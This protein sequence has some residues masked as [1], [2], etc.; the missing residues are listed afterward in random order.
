MTIKS[1]VL[2]LV[3]IMIAIFGIIG[4]ADA[5]YIGQTG[6]EV[7]DLQ[8]TL[9]EAGYD[10][11]ALSSGVAQPGYFGVQTQRALAKYEA[12]KPRTF[13]ALSSPTVYEPVE[14]NGGSKFGSVNSTSTP[15]S[16]TLRLSDVMN[17]D[18]VIVRPTGAAASKTLT[19]FASSTAANWLPKAGDTQRTC[20][21]NAT[22]S[23][24]ATIVFAAGAGIDL[25]AT[26]TNLTVQADN[27]TCFTF[28][29]KAQIAGVTNSFDIS[30]SMFTFYDAD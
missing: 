22:T 9:L 3:V 7:A 24:A 4:T 23:A 17:Y 10:I 6:G 14:L 21:L 28:I 25:Q 11:P 19:F 26:S 30:A 1:K 2:S 15:A 16:M 8:I 13:G 20:F 5:Y 29:R 12:S 27:S 18:T